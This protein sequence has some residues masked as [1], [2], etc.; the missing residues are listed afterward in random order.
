MVGA[1]SPVVIARTIIPK[2]VG[3]RNFTM[4]KAAVRNQTALRNP[5]P[6]FESG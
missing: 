3:R 5:N 1:Q 6:P 2:I 4:W